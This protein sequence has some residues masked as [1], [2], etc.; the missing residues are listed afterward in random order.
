MDDYGFLDLLDDEFFK[1]ETT[2][3]N[4]DSSDARDNDYLEIQ[5]NGTLDIYMHILEMYQGY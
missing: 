3:A 2:V 4:V 1:D 5:T